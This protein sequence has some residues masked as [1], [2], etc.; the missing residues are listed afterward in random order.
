VRHT[1]EPLELFFFFSCL[2]AH[3]HWKKGATYKGG[4]S[5]EVSSFVKRSLLEGSQ[6][7][8]RDTGKKEAAPAPEKTH[9]FY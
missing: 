1:G 5:K 9:M 7:R 2:K 4:S 3:T 6:T 8:L